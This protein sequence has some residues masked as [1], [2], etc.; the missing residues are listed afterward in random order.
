MT[1]RPEH[2]ERGAVTVE[3]ALGLAG[4]VVL[5]GLV[6]LLTSAATAQL[7]C[8]EAARAGARAAA[9]GQEDPAVLDVARRS[10]G[11]EARVEV[12]RADGWVTVTVG[13]SVAGSWHLGALDA[14]ARSSTPVE[15]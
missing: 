15:P 9:L 2:H 5:L 7:R 10:A 1:A 13:R 14:Q 12:V 8:A 6:L 11:A 3:L 4:V